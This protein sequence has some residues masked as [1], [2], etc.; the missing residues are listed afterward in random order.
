MTVGIKV[1]DR[2]KQTV[3]IVDQETGK[4]RKLIRIIEVTG[5]PTLS[6]P[7]NYEIVRNDAHP[8]RVGKFASIRRSQLE[9][10][11]RAVS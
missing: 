6:S 3:R 8:H 1:G 10:K 7:V 9:R 5:R 2:F 11:Y 4:E